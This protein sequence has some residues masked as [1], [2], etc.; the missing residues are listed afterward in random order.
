[1]SDKAMN[2]MWIATVEAE[3]QPEDVS[4]GN[5]L[6]FM[7]ITMWASSREEFLQKVDHYFGE[8]NWKIISIDNVEAVEFS[9]D[10]GDEIN[11]M[12]DE[13]SQNRDWVRLGTFFSY[14]PN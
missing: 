8:Y 7:R 2:Q 11:Q 12:I 5:R 14:K 4:S 6:G 13:T 3:L 9:R 1:M 10:Y